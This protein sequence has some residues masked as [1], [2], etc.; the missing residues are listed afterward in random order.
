MRVPHRTD[1]AAAASFPGV[2]LPSPYQPVHD[3]RP[4][5]QVAGHHTVVEC[6]HHLVAAH[7]PPALLADDLLRAFELE[8]SAAMGSP[9]YGA[10]ANMEMARLLMTR[11]RQH[12]PGTAA[13][14]LEAA[15]STARSLG[16]A[17]LEAEV[18]SILRTLP[19]ETPLSAP[20]KRS[21]S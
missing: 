9:T 19:K 12:D 10:I 16:M 18:S 5:V 3:H 1:L 4:R 11:R 21:P 14:H 20:E 6:G 13:L 2:A 8:L 15:L 17:P 7:A